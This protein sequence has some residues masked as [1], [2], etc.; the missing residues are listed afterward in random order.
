MH[1]IFSATVDKFAFTITS[2]LATIVYILL[3]NFI[4]I[5]YKCN[6]GELSLS[7]GC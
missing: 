5:F 3:F 1:V 7:S 2:Y 6:E 4:V